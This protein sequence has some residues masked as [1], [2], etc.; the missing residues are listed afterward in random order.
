MLLRVGPLR[1]FRELSFE[2][3]EGA[4]SVPRVFIKTLHDQVIQ[5]HQQE[6]M[7]RRW[8]PSQV[9]ALESDHSPFFSTPSLLFA[10]LL[11]A[12]ASI[13]SIDA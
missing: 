7:I 9:F 11:Q 10:F 13:N 6:A 4:D 12:V 1:P 5:Q 8:P 3:T 2:A